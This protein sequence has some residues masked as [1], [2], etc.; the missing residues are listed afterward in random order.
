MTN[1]KGSYVTKDDVVIAKNYLSEIELNKLNLLVSG[2]LDYAELQALELKLMKMVDWVKFLDKQ[3]IN[4]KKNLLVGSGTISH[5]AAV[6]KTE[7]EYDLYR[8][9][10]IKELQSDFDLLMKSIPG[11]KDN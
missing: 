2:Y 6:K 5:E 4:M 3:I 1:F 9:K 11:N 10:E 7:K 8:E